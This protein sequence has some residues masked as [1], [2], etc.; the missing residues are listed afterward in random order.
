MDTIMYRM[1][2]EKKGKKGL[3]IKVGGCYVDS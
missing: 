1:W 2:V 3:M